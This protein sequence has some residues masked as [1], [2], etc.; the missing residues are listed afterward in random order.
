MKEKKPRQNEAFLRDRTKIRRSRHYDR[1]PINKKI[2][3]KEYRI[4][5]LDENNNKER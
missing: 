2:D 5:T 3:P 1:M 4:A